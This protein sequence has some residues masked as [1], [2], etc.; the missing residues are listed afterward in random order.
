MGVELPKRADVVIVGGGII[1]VS[2]AYHLAAAGVDVVLLERGALAS[3]STSKALG[4]IR[5]SFNHPVNLQMGKYGREV[6]GRFVE[7]FDQ[8]INYVAGGYLYLI[9]DSVPMEHME[10]AVSLQAEYGVNSRIIDPSEINAISPIV[11]AGA[12]VAAL[13]SP[14]DA[15]AE[16]EPATQ[17][18]A[19]AARAAGACLLTHIDVVGIDVDEGLIRSVITSAGTIATECVVNCGGAWAP[20]VARMIGWD[21]PIT[22]YRR[23]VVTTVD[24]RDV[25][26]H[27][28]LT[29]DLATSFY[30]HQ[31]KQK[32]TVG[33]SDPLEAPGYQLA[34]DPTE[35]LP[36]MLEKAERAAPGLLDLGIQSGYAGLY[37]ITP[38]HNQLIGEHAGVSR[39]LYAAG[40]SGHG[41][42]MGPA[43]GRII[44][45]LYLGQEPFIDVSSLDASRFD[46]E[47]SGARE[48]FIV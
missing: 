41:F 32:F 43:T 48:A 15:K 4:G 27:E 30:F 31:E 24:M 46:G 17:G 6:Y 11:N 16:P 2:V 5:A 28:T 44:T 8:P 47:Y 39:F 3:G 45:S 9:D 29:I 25:E 14:D 33:Y 10:A 18:Y 42:Q 22:P 20:G 26:P 37:A 36:R 19:R 38:D 7:A 40:F 21:M 1:G 13:W 23:Q 34:Y 12:F 35:W